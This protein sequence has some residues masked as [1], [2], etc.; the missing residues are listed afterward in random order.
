MPLSHINEFSR[1]LSRHRRLRRWCWREGCFVAALARHLRWRF[2]IMTVLLATGAV[3]FIRLEP[4]KDHSPIEAI[5]MTWSLVFGQPAEALPRSPFLQALFFL[6]PII[7][8][9]I[10]IEGI[11]DLA[12]VLRD[13][14]HYERSWCQAMAD[15]LSDHIILVGLGRLGYRTWQI[16]NQLDEPMVV[17]ESK[18]DASFLNELRRSGT[19]F[20]IGDGRVDDILIE[21][22]ITRARSIILATNDDLAN[23]EMALD[24]RRLNPTIRVVLRMFDQSL[25]NKIKEG[26]DIHLAMSQSAISAPAFATA[27]L[28]R[29]IVNSFVIN[30]QLIVLQRQSLGAGHAWVGLTVG[31]VARTIG[32]VVVE[33]RAG[34]ESRLFPE[35]ERRL[36]AH[37]ELLVQGPFENL[38]R[39]VASGRGPA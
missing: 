12:R 36:V 19:P 33:V 4:E 39:R 20:L 8:L 17:I 31:E 1:P 16:L 15:S 13:R 28:D 38:R 7:G 26:F 2:L 35:S 24:S 25:A 30:N 22:G 3:L 11:I 21:A 6:V 29:S 18:A 32:G 5:Y 34:K 37:E 14:R 27:A 9:T 23:M 10:V